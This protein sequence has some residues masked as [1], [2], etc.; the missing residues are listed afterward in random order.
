MGPDLT[1]DLGC[2]IRILPGSLV[3]ALSTF[4]PP[5]RAPGSLPPYSTNIFPFG[6]EILWRKRRKMQEHVQEQVQR[7]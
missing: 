3:R 7:R 6:P 5:F 4:S 2:T 1:F